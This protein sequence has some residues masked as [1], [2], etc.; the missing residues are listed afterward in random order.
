[1]KKEAEAAPA[2][3]AEIAGQVAGLE[4]QLQGQKAVAHTA[5]HNSSAL[6]ELETKIA[7]LLTYAITVVVA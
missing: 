1:M 4:A 3:L 6:Q 5:S 7:A 2:R